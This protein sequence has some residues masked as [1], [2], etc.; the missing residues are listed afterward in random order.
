MLGA[1][2]AGG[3]SKAEGR[4]KGMLRPRGR[5]E[6]GPACCGTGTKG[7]Q[8]GHSQPGLEDMICSGGV[9]GQAAWLQF[10]RIL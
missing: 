2:H 7:V 10:T 1:G 5:D 6:L 8:G 3:L 9:P 4:R